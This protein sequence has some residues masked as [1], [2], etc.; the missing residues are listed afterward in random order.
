MIG[1]AACRGAATIVNA[2]ATG[3][4]AAF[5]ISLEADAAVQL[6]HGRGE[7]TLASGP[8]GKDLISGCVQA[9]ASK[10]MPGHE[11]HGG[12][13]VVSE[14]PVSR[15]LKSSSAVSNAIVLATARALGVNLP[16]TE[17]ILAGVEASLKAG[18]TVTGA[19]DDASACFLGGVVMTD[20]RNFTVLGRGTLD[21]DLEILLHVPER[22]ISKASVKD[23]D[24]SKIEKNIEKAFDLALKGEFLR[25]ME[26]NSRAYAKVLDVSEEVADLAR[27]KGALAAGISGTGPA[28]VII[29][30]RAEAGDIMSALRRQEGSVLVAKVND[31]PAKEVVPR[32]L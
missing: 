3:K 1:R 26:L 23:L 30:D 15:G 5:G 28:T 6:E 31:T 27:K 16:D 8:E 18:V 29:C 11:V 32:L 21:P 19:F 14:I 2:I 24:F 17:L 10:A 13:R 22:R 25:A 4:G 9:V 7:L 20:N 12:V